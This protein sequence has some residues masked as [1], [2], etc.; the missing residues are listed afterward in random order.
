MCFRFVMENMKPGEE[1]QTICY[2]FGQ[3]TVHTFEQ[4]LDNVNK[5]NIIEGL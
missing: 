2:L 1:L 4:V 5:N 3:H